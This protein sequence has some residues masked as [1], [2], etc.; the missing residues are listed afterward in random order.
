MVRYDLQEWCS[1]FT[2]P[3]GRISVATVE[4]GSE[5]RA[6]RDGRGPVIAGARMTVIDLATAQ[7]AYSYSPDELAYQYPPLT[8]GQIHLYM[9]HHVRRAITSGLR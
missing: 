9:D 4:T 6:L 1:G 8:P 5:Q 2:Q 7:Q 3:S